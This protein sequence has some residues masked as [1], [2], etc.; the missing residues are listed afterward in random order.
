MWIEQRQIQFLPLIAKKKG[1][2]FLLEYGGKH[3][4]ISAHQHQYFEQLLGGSSVHKLVMDFVQKGWL[5]SFRELF[6]LLDT[7]VQNH[8]IMNP[9]F[10]SYFE[11][12]KAQSS[13][14]LKQVALHQGKVIA[15]PELIKA[16][17]FFR[18][19]SSELLKLF[20]QNTTVRE[21]PA[22]TR[23]CQAG[24]HSRELF[25]MIK[26]TLGV[27]RVFPDGKRQLVSTVPEGSVF[28]E[29]GFLLG[30]PRGAD[31][32][33][34]QPSTIAVIN[35]VPEF[36]VITNSGKA[37]AL[38]R[39]F[40][41]LQGLLASEVFSHIPTETLDSLVFAGK[42][43]NAK[44][45]D[46]LAREGEPG[47]SFF[48][49]IQGSIAFSQGGK[50]LRALAQGGI[51]GEIALMVSGG[52]RTATARAQKDSLLLQIEMKEF[53]ELMSK[54]LILAKEIES[55]AWKRWET[56]TA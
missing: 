1:D 18:Q 21:V 17:P 19:L 11:M 4:Q 9:E 48:V 22:H 26:G 23:I 15:N 37:E 20:V 35:H 45:G 53:Y 14:G 52:K 46:V 24:D 12:A 43:L 36:E 34:L 32:V 54:N 3:A 55:I 10:Q 16:L 30:K 25:A 47:S 27:Y 33:C 28:G 42:I 41:V 40:W 7:C 49:I 56:R 13:S 31:V 51:F 8:W 39:R 6:Q 38:Q 2:H 5:V 44:E 50:S 29:G